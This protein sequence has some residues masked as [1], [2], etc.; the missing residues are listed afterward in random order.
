[1]RMAASMRDA[2]SGKLDDG[3]ERPWTFFSPFIQCV[4][5]LT[6]YPAAARRPG[7]GRRPSSADR[8]DMS[9]IGASMLPVFHDEGLKGSMSRAFLSITTNSLQRAAEPR[10]SMS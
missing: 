10:T 1:M 7:Y 2:L 6:N 9:R 8:A 3:G 4:V 5:E